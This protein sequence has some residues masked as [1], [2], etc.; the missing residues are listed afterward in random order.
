[1]HG[2][3]QPPG[4]PPYP[5]QPLHPAALAPPRRTGILAGLFDFSFETFVAARLVKIL[6]ICSLIGVSIVAAIGLAG[7]VAGL[8]S[9]AASG[10]V[11]VITAPLGWL[12]FLALAR[13]W[14]ERIIVIFKISDDLRDIRDSGPTWP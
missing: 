5:S 1:M 3:W 9:G 10:V 14:L 13:L 11:A 2:G 7:G 6:Y 12:F 8:A 4:P